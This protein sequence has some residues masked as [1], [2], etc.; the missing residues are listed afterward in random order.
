MKKHIPVF[1]LILVITLLACSGNY[2]RVKAVSS[3]PENFMDFMQGGRNVAIVMQKSDVKFPDPGWER[4]LQAEMENSIRSL[5]YFNIVDI[6]TRA[7]RLKEMTRTQTGLTE[8]EKEVGREFALDGILYF[9]AVQPPKSECVTTYR[10]KT[11]FPCADRKKCP[12]KKV[13]ITVK[14]LKFIIYIKGKLVNT[15]TGQS[16]AFT[17]TDP[18][19][20]VR[21]GEKDVKCATEK[22]GFPQA[23]KQ[24]VRKLAYKLS[25]AVSNMR[26]EIG[27]DPVGAPKNARK[28][29]KKLLKQGNKWAKT[30]KQ[31]LVEAKKYWQ[32][33]LSVSG[34][35]S[36]YA[37]WNLAVA[38]WSEGDLNRAEDYF[39]RAI[40]SGGSKFSEKSKMW[41]INKFRQERERIE[42]ENR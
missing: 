2:I 33:A 19:P 7:V 26:I 40:S 32:Q 28:K 11:V 37:F 16:I 9:K 4:I 24:T 8:E 38:M 14:T 18:I 27:D 25:P 35:R 22:Q 1:G 17:N 21:K 15:E 30:G 29:V 42:R 39:N 6:K 13:K 12:P 34:N 5:G 23:A 20:V 41:V 10:T 3:M 36:A 31:N